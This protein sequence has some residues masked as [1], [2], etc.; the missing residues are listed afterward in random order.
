M[1][2]FDPDTGKM[3]S[4]QRAQTGKAASG[5]E[6]AMAVEE[7][8]ARCK[9]KKYGSALKELKRLFTTYPQLKR[10]A[11]K[12]GEHPVSPLIELFVKEQMG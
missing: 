9:N 7:A 5:N 2:Y 10:D 6:I 11:W 8:V 12:V 4:G 3:V 1:G